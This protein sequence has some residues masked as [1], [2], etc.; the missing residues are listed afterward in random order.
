MKKIIFIAFL[1]VSPLAFF[2]CDEYYK[3]KQVINDSDYEVKF[4]FN[5]FRKIEYTLKPHTSEYY[6]E[7]HYT[8]KSYSATPP[9]VIY[10]IDYNKQI[11]TF[12]NTPEKKMKI[13]NELDKNVLITAN[14][15]INNE[16]ITI[17]ANNEMIVSIYS[18][19]PKLIGMTDID[20][21]PVNFSY[22]VSSILVHW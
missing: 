4:I 15:C 9:R 20:Y 21:Y 1:V 7:N 2:G 19:T 22:G 14:G 6:S 8:I 13:I 12:Y 11:V 16:P 10:S 3:T 17:P 18:I 5:H